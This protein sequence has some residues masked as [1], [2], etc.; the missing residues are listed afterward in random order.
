MGYFIKPKSGLEYDKLDPI[1]SLYYAICLQAIKD[2]K[3][4]EWKDGVYGY[5]TVKE[6]LEAVDFVASILESNGYSDTEIA[7]VFK[8]IVPP[9]YKY[10]L[11]QARLAKRGIKI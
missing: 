6:G 7:D 2:V 11:I 4:L 9:N 8:K 5:C 3:A 1:E 10:M